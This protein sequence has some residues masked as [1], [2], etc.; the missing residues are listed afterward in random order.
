MDNLVNPVL[1]SVWDDTAPYNVSP[2]I[3]KY[4]TNLNL[5]R[6]EISQLTPSRTSDAFPQTIPITLYT[7]KFYSTN[8]LLI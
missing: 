8:I 7:Y 4:T 2:R 3:K 5:Q 6:K 1:H